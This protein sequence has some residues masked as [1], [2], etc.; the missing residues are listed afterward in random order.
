MEE[1][2]YPTM[3]VDKI[4]CSYEIK[5]YIYIMQIVSRYLKNFLMLRVRGDLV[6]ELRGFRPRLRRSTLF[7]PELPLVDDQYKI[8]T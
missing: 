7:V 6:K 5:F 1:N 3:Y 8:H 4:R 2:I